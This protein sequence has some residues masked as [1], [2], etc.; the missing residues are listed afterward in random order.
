MENGERAA[1]SR[2]LELLEQRKYREALDLLKQHLSEQTDGEGHALL[3]LAY[4]H[5]EEYPSAVEQ[6]T[7]ALQHDATNPQ[8][9]LFVA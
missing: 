5:L 6:Y 7:V 4:Y 8:R 2:A 9:S 1:R 3:A